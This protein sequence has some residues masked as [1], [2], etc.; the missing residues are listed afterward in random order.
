MTD[1]F[2][3]FLNHVCGDRSI[4]KVSYGNH[5]ILTKKLFVHFQLRPDLNTKIDE[6][7]IWYGFRDNDLIKPLVVNNFT[8]HRS[9]QDYF[10]K[11]I[12]KNKTK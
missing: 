10:E 5:C 11:L 7:I 1:H 6:P 2:E 12:H 8:I 3:I 4:L 9:E